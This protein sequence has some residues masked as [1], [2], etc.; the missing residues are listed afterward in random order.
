MIYDQPLL[1]H[2]ETIVKHCPYRRVMYNSVGEFSVI[3][4][5]TK[6][7]TMV[8]RGP[9][10]LKMILVKLVPICAYFVMAIIKKTIRH[11]PP[12]QNE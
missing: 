11:V 8:V 2:S 9:N 3:L 7:Y 6:V 12:D 5:A 1:R 4:M 10:Q